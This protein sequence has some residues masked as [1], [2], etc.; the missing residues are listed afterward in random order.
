MINVLL[1]LLVTISPELW[2]FGKMEADNNHITVPLI[3]TF[4]IIA[5]WEYNRNV[6]YINILAAAWLINAS[7]LL[8]F[9]LKALLL[10][11]SIG[12]IVL[13]LSLIKGRIKKRYGGGWRSL[14]QKN[15]LHMQDRSV[16]TDR[17]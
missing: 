5:L 12:L 13:L 14:W 16:N 11:V 8:R 17:S 4:S 3:I 15:P 6:R 7:L 1:G 2:R 10:N 9:Q